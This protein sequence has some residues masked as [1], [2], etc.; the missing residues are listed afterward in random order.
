MAMK[1]ALRRGRVAARLGFGA[2]T[3]VVGASLLAFG[4]GMAVALDE[5]G[6]E[7]DALKACEKQFCE[8]VMK[9]EATG[10]D[11]ACKLSKTWTKTKI[12]DG[13]EKKKLTWGFGDARCAIDVAVKRDDILAAVSKP[14]H[15]LE[16]APQTV[17]CQVEREKEVTEI[18]VTLAP[19][20][21]FKNGKADKAWINVK[22]IEAPTIIKGAIW[23]AAQI[24]SNLGLFHADM[25]SE[26]NEF[27]GEKCPKAV[28]P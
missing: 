5:P 6:S 21:S 2:A 3:L 7:R 18:S 12:Q 8:I 25:I 20:I 23:T 17:K 19:K 24:E 15:A 16:F 10:A 28:A 4:S 14:E 13:I 11:F 9:K 22:E 1:T 27:V 26:I